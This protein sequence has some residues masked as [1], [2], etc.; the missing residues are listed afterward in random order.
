MTVYLFLNWYTV[1][2][3]NFN[4]GKLTLLSYIDFEKSPLPDLKQRIKI[5]LRTQQINFFDY[6]DRY[7][8]Q[9][10][11]LKSKFIRDDFLNYKKQIKFDKK[12]VDL[13]LFDFS[14]FDPSKSEFH[15]E[16]MTIGYT[17]Q[18]YHIIKN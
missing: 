10:L 1:T 4:S 7:S 17:I 3:F 18:R 16:I 15:E 11:Y 5:N 2:R 8:Y 13:N 14:G 9:P 12:S 6:G